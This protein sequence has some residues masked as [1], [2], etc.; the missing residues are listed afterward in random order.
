MFHLASD[1]TWVVIRHS[2][3][4]GSWWAYKEIG[5]EAAYQMLGYMTYPVI[6]QPA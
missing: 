5:Q 6:P 1:S 2:I 4:C 3:R